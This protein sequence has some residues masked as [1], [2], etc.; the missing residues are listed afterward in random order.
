MS[1]ISR[2]QVM[3]LYCSS[4][5]KEVLYFSQ[6]RYLEE[7]PRI[8]LLNQ[9]HAVKQDNS[10]FRIQSCVRTDSCFP[11]DASGKEP[12]SQCRRGKRC[13]FDLWVEKILWRR[14]WQFIPIFLPGESHGQRSLVGYS[15]QGLTELDKTEAAQQTGRQTDRLVSQGS[16]SGRGLSAKQLNSIIALLTCRTICISLCIFFSTP[17]SQDAPTACI[18]SIHFLKK[19]IYLFIF[20]FGSA[21]SLLLL[22]GSFSHCGEQGLLQLQCS[23]FSLQQ[24]LLLQSTGP[25]VLRLQQLWAQ[26][27]QL[28]GSRAGS[29]VV[30]HE[31]SCPVVCGIFLDQAS[32]WCALHCKAD[33]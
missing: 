25:R 10:V 6:C 4:I 3:W 30:V 14:A 29:V 5:L 31:L 33:S 28:M 17:S 21:G 19:N 24:L 2:I 20:I 1:L 15:S 22:A 16:L 12:T 9:V 18:I 32:N 11:G 26:Y 8:A 27:L 23:G 7:K 13:R